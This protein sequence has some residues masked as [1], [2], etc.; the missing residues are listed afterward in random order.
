VMG[1]S[2]VPNAKNP[3]PVGSIIS[4]FGTGLGPITPAQGDGTVVGF[5]LPT[6]ALPVK[7]QASIGGFSGTPPLVTPYEVT[8]A[9][10]A[11]YLIAG[12]SQITFKVIPNAGPIQV[13]LP[14][15]QS[16]FFQ[17]YVAGQ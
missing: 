15:T 17:I 6:N 8:Y 4:A 11:P 9:G 14:S 13:I 3:A 1:P 10:P 5:P 2:P 16:Q 7:V 12:A